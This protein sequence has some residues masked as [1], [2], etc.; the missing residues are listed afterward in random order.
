MCT[1]VI[2][3]NNSSLPEV[4]GNAGIMIQAEDTKAL[5]NGIVK[6][7]TNQSLAKS[8]STRGLKQAKK[9]SWS[10]GAKTLLRVIEDVSGSK[11]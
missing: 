2:T 10:I 1:P 3:S 7:I 8:M 5:T 11:A 9:F 6:I 4:V